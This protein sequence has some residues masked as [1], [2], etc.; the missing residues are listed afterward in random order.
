[1]K[2]C[3]SGRQPKSVLSQ[4]DEI[5]MQYRDRD[6]LI[7]YTTEF[8]DKTFILE[9]PKEINSDEINWELYKA[10]SD[11]VNFMLCIHNLNLAK[12]CHAH[13]IKFYWAYPVFTW[14]E[15]QGILDLQPCYLMLNA[16]LSFSLAKVKRKTDI[17]IRMCPNLAYDAYIPRNTGVYG[18]WVRPEDINT[19][20]EWVD[21]F[22]FITD[23]LGKESTLLHIYKDNGSWPGNLNL[24]LTNF[25]VNVDNRAI[26]EEIG[27]YRANCGQ[28]CMES[29]TCHFCETAMKFSNAIRTK[30]YKDNKLTPIQTEEEN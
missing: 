11:K 20:G 4:A 6:R 14:Y 2:Y 7:D 29:S 16:P 5:K 24:L 27:Q 8:N 13:G 15:L 10:Y 19:Y 28:R 17:P 3:I 1:M 26:P 12:D 23:D 18:T 22:E 30:H 21:T 9:V 25:N